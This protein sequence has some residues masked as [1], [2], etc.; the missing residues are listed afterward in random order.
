[1]TTRIVTDNGTPIQVFGSPEAPRGLIVLQEAFGITDHIREV[2]QRFAHE[3]Y[4]VAA[5]ELFHRVGS[6][7]FGYDDYAS[8]APAMAS[9]N[10][11]G[12]AEDLTGAA[13]FLNAAGYPNASIGVVGYCMGGSVAFYADTLGLV[14]AAATFYGGGVATGRFGLAPLVELAASLRA[15][16]LGLYGDLDQGIP[17]EDVEALRTAASASHV[18]TEIVRYPNA[19][20]GFNCDARPAAYNADAS[21]DATQRTLEFFAANLT[22]K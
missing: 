16:W 6:P 18:T 12:L 11:D 2:S 9:L 5:P 3:G 20:H 7:E 1:M 21:A 10:P 22:V 13:T 8:V 15:P 19:N 14:G 4:Y 17:P